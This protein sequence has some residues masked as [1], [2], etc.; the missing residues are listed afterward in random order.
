MSNKSPFRRKPGSKARHGKPCDVPV[1][2]VWI[3]KDL[4]DPSGD[5]E[6]AKTEALELVRQG[7]LIYI[8]DGYAPTRK[9]PKGD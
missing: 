1:D 8:G 9:F 3:R 4:E 2:M 6:I 5:Y 7:K